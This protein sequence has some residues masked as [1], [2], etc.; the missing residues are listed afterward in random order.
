[1]YKDTQRYKEYQKTYRQKHKE[2]VKEYNKKYWEENKEKLKEENRI[3]GRKW[4]QNNKQRNYERTKKWQQNNRKRAVEMTQKYVIGHKEKVNEYL[5]KYGLSLDGYYRRYK[6]RAKKAG[7]KMTL[8]LKDFDFITSNQCSYCGE[9]EKRRGI[10]RVDNSVG[11][12]KENCVS[13][14]GK[15]NMMKMKLS[16][17]DF[18]S[19]IKKIYEYNI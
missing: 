17:E 12:L 6:Y 15:C 5:K 7:Y 16:K 3:R 19:H 8:S 11:Y 13:C 14:C 18:L 4:Y 9:K 1:M 10:D 2:K